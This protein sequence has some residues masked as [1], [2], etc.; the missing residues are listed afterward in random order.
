MFGFW[1]RR[2]CL[3]WH[4]RVFFCRGT[5]L[6]LTSLELSVRT[7]QSVPATEGSVLSPCGGMDHSP[8]H[9]LKIQ[10]DGRFSDARE[11]G[12]VPGPKLAI[13]VRACCLI[14]AD[15]HEAASL[16]V[17]PNEAEI[18]GFDAEIAAT[19]CCIEG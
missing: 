10:R 17:D 8:S 3:R 4:K 18:A 19:C 14:P 5:L 11:S 13:A 7:L 6:F 16:E 9:F 2:P 12:R 15:W 1:K